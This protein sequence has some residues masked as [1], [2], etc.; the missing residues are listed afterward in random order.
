MRKIIAIAALVALMTALTAC[1]GAPPSESHDWIDIDGLTV[2]LDFTAEY[3]SSFGERFTQDE[4]LQRELDWI[5]ANPDH[6]FVFGSLE[7]NYW[8]H[9]EEYA[10]FTVAHRGD[11]LVITLSLTTPSAALSDVIDTVTRQSIFLRPVQIH[12]PAAAAITHWTITITLDPNTQ[13]HEDF[14]LEFSPTAVTTRILVAIEEA[15]A[16]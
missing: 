10:N 9:E 7:P 1:I 4:I 6:E 11:A 8:W 2:L 13:L 15:R 3:E 5:A 12:D 16:Q 14:H